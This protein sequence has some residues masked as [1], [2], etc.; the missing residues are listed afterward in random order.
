MTEDIPPSTVGQ[1]VSQTLGV[2]QRTLGVVVRIALLAQIPLIAGAPFT[3]Q[4]VVL[5]L[6]LVS[7]FTGLLATAAITYTVGQFYLGRSTTVARSLVGALENGVSLLINAL[8]FWAAVFLATL[9]SLIVIG[10]PVL[11]FVV[12]AWFAFVQGVVIENK[13][14][15]EALARSWELVRGNWWRVFG[16]GLVFLAVVLAANFIVS[17]PGILVGLANDTLGRILTSLAG[18]LVTPIISIATTLV[19]LDLRVRKESLT[20]ETLASELG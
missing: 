2:Y 8:V 3:S 18:A 10:I 5:A 12:V 1:L 11:V 17:L 4:S 7:A 20:L 19:Y 6:L 9:L 15:F 14:P 13:G 16:I